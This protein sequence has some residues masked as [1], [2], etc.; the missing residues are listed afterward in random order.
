MKILGDFHLHT[1]ASQHAYSTVTEYAAYASQKQLKII[2][3]SDHG[4]AMVDAPHEYYFQNL[5]ILPRTM[6]GV[7]I[8][9]GA[10]LN[11]IDDAGAV[12]L[13]SH[14]LEQLDY[15]IASYHAGII[16]HNYTKEQHTD[17]FLGVLDLPYRVI[18]GHCDNPK[19]PVHFEPILEKAKKVGAL[20]EVN[21]ASYGY[22]RPGSYEVGLE[23][24]RLAKAIGNDIILNSDAHYHEDVGNVDRCM[25]L[26][27]EAGFPADRI[28]NFSMEKIQAFFRL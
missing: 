2:G 11:I 7:T 10:E 3:I 25:G 8:L 15:M 14:V 28:V 24:L 17:G 23:V 16:P 5:R 6:S 4:P 12:D 18:L 26:V 13:K 27:K 22:I 21:N 1:V 9:R 20:I 19:I